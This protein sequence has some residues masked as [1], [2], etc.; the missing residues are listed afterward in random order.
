MGI[1][2]LAINIALGALIMTAIALGA[3]GVFREGNARNATPAGRIGL[4]DWWVVL[5]G[6]MGVVEIAV[7]A[8]QLMRD[9]RWENGVALGVVGWG[10][11]GQLLPARPDAGPAHR[12]RCSAD[13]GRGSLRALPRP[14]P[15]P[16]PV[17]RL[18]LRSA[19][20]R[21]HRCLGQ[22]VLPGSACTCHCSAQAPSSANDGCTA[23]A[24]SP[25]HGSSRPSRWAASSSFRS[26]SPSC[27]RRPSRGRRSTRSTRSSVR[28]TPGRASSSRSERRTRAC[29]S[30]SAPVPRCS[31]SA[32]GGGRHRPAGVRH[33]APGRELGA[34]QL[35]AV[36]AARWAARPDR[37]ALLARLPPG[38]VRG[39]PPDRHDPQPRRPGERGAR[40]ADLVGGTPSRL[41]AGDLAQPPPLQLI[42]SRGHQDRAMRPGDRAR[43]PVRLDGGEVEFEDA[44]A[45][46][47]EEGGGR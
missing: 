18:G 9:P 20:D 19:G 23:G 28:P 4:R 46:T 27:P 3:S 6:L 33:R 17:R 16:V 15:P 7:V 29:R 44:M 24:D 35:L 31:R 45:L 26:R 43:G 11:G 1:G 2:G 5:A 42:A 38:A 14:A 32:T 22:A 40:R 21:P 34:Q 39:P 8:G 10:G 36:G 25:G 47:G 30:T 12:P 13:L 37:R 41:V